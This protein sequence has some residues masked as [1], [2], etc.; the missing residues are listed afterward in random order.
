MRVI[1]A[2]AS[3]RRRELLKQIGLNFEIDVSNIE[4]S[5]DSS[6]GPDEIAT[7]LAMQKAVDVAKR[8]KDDDCIIIG[9]D[10]IVVQGSSIL[11]KPKDEHEAKKML[12]ALQGKSHFVLT[13]IALINPA[14]GKF[15]SDYEKTKVTFCKMSPDE[16]ERY[17][18][19]KEPLDK[20]GAYGIQGMGSKY[21]SSIQGDFFNVVGL[22]ICRMTQILNK[23][24]GFYF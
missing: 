22:P 12:S 23:Q 5:I 14:E 20:A 16:I 21:I 17:V 24:F 3:A 2:S 13:G 19:T 7:L 8:Y 4:E 1:L 18:S 10:T 11:G 15:V 6:M 9:A